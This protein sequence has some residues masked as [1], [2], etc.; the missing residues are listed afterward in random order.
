MICKFCSYDKAKSG[1]AC[2]RCGKVSYEK[3][4]KKLLV[5]MIILFILLLVHKI[6]FAGI[7]LGFDQAMVSA[8]AFFADTESAIEFG[9]ANPSAYHSLVM[10]RDSYLRKF[11]RIMERLETEDGDK[12]WNLA[13]KFAAQAQFMREAYEQIPNGAGFYAG[14]IPIGKE[15]K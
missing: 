11:D 5:K 2:A 7:T 4:S 1:C 10:K 15:D 9:K 8:P 12:L 3:R 13:S 14:S 6:C